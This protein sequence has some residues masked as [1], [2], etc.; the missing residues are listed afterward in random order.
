MVHFYLKCKKNELTWADDLRSESRLFVTWFGN[1]QQHF[2]SMMVVSTST[3]TGKKSGS[4]TF[5]KWYPSWN[6]VFWSSSNLSSIGVVGAGWISA[7]S[8]TT[9][10][11][12]SW[13]CNWTTSLSDW[14]EKPLL[15]TLKVRAAQ[16][17]SHL[18][19]KLSLIK[20]AFSGLFVRQGLVCSRQF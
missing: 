3:S 9:I 19:Q 2:S 16:R 11:D 15:L 1:K 12:Q 14:E 13:S 5:A 20:W 18:V 6:W 7:G 8:E 4:A 10:L 17:N